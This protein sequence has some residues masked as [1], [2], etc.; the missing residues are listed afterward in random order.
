MLGCEGGFPYLIAGKYSEDFGMVEESC[1]PYEAIQRKCDSEER[2]KCK[3][4]YFSYEYIGG[5]YGGL[6]GS[7]YVFEFYGFAITN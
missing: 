4:Y 2:K 7:P 1:F 3:K 5:Y 6:V